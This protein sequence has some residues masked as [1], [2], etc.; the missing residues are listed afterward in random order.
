MDDRELLATVT[1]V[2][3]PSAVAD[4][5]AVLACGADLLVVSTDMLHETTDFPSGM[6]DSQIGWMAVAVTLSDIAAMGAA[7][8]AVLIAAGLD[9][10]QRLEGILRGARACADAHGCGIVGGDTDAHT[11]LTIVT[12]GIGRVSP[13]H[14]VRRS[15]ARPGD[16][17][18]LVGTPGRAQAGL[19]GYPGHRTALI[20][21]LPLVREGLALGRAGVSAM[22][23]VSD[24]LLLSLHDLCEAC[25]C[26]FSVVSDTIPLP[27]GVEPELGR[28]MA[29]SGG[30]DF[31]LL[32]T[33]PPERFPVKG[34]DARVIGRVTVEKRVTID[35]QPA[36]HRGY[37]HTW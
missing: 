15:G 24:G 17:V 5:C 28:E 10:W 18:C 29:L 22:M 19:L 30:G 9:R 25:G 33:C 12:T 14:L 2:L 20:E 6:T 4:D 1:A 13:A 34:V 8:E 36:S 26:G 37:C 27:E 31:G 32:F 23:D 11:E 7:P 3:G 35:G 16:L 21:P